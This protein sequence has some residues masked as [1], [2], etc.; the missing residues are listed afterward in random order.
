MF[1]KCLLQDH[2]SVKSVCVCVC[3]LS[4]AWLFAIPWTVACQVPLSIEFSRQE[5]WSGFPFPI[6][7]DLPN[8]G[9]KPESLHW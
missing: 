6:T 3:G 2:F 7:R 4:C 5:Y 9:I 8:P 1:V